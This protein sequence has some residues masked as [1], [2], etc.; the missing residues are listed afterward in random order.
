[1]AIAAVALGCPPTMPVDTTGSTSEATTTEV[2][3]TT[4]TMSTTSGETGIQTV[5][6]GT[7]TA[8]EGSTTTGPD[9]CPKH[10]DALAAMIGAGEPCDVLVHLDEA[11]APV[12]LDAVCGQTGAV[13]N[14]GKDIGAMTGCCNEGPAIYPGMMD[15]PLYVLNQVYPQA[16][17]GVAI[18]SNHTGQVLLDAMTGEGSPG[19]VAVP[20]SWTDP[21][22]L[23]VG[24]GCGDPGFSLA[25]ALSYDLLQG[26]AA[27]PAND[28]EVLAVAIG[29]MALAPA[30]AQVSTPVHTAVVRY[31][32][33]DGGP[34]HTFVVLAVDGA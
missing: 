10:V 11:A 34:A 28:L 20:A 25:T 13:W 5:T 21:A 9:V 2:P 29:D 27:L 1:M 24:M 6:S 15:A 16:P 22:A 3:A 30:L 8:T 17:D 7:L 26:G 12:G 23:A 32:P 31:A 4:T 33:E 14:L 18:L 19:P